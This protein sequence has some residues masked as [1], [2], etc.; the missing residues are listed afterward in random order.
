[1][2]ANS[3]SASE[4][5]TGSGATIAHRVDLSW[6][7]STSTSVAGYN[8][9]RAPSTTSSY[10]RINPVLN[11]SMS[12]S[13]STVQSG[14]TYYYATTAVDSSGVESTY[15]NKVQVAIPFP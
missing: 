5:A 6:D 8:I 3:T 13:D 12:Y 1:M 14:Q 15:S 2:A 7:A 4:I 10:S 9:Y 11:P